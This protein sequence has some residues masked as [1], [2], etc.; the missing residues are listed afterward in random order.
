MR[1]LPCAHRPAADAKSSEGQGSATPR[2]ET[3]GSNVPAAARV[4]HGGVQCE[5][6]G[7]GEEEAEGL[8]SFSTAKFG[9]EER[10]RQP[11]CA[12]NSRGN[13][14]LRRNRGAWWPGCGQGARAAGTCHFQEQR[15]GRYKAATEGGLSMMRW[16]ARR[17]Y[18]RGR[19]ASVGA[20]GI[21]PV[22]CRGAL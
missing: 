15:P 20:S 3:F 17:R 1:F 10:H 8:I 16:T 11:V 12:A 2:G 21:C 18:L 19:W 5:Q 14:Q 13:A 7:Q 6:R 9:V 4:E 22:G